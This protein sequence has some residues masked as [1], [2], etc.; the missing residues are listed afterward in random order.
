MTLHTSSSPRAATPRTVRH[1]TAFEQRSVLEET[2]ELTA[3][4]LDSFPGY[5]A[6]LDASGA[7]FAAN[8]PWI[9]LHRER[10]ED[11]IAASGVG[12]NYCSALRQIASRGREH[13]VS[14]MRELDDLLGGSG[15][16]ERVELICETPDGR[17]VAIVGQRLRRPAGGAA[18]TAV[19]I[20]AWATGA[21]ALQR[22]QRDLMDAAPFAVAGE[23]VGGIAHDL[24]QPL[25]SMQVNLDT[26]SYMLRQDP[27]EVARALD[28]LA[29]A[30]SD[31]RTLRDSVQLLQDLVARREPRLTTVSLDGVVNDVARL[32]HGEAQARRVHLDV[33][34]A[35]PLSPVHADRAMLREAVLGLALDAVEQ[36]DVDADTRVFLHAR[37]TEAS[38]ELS[39]GHQR[40]AGRSVDGWILA[41]AR[42]V[43]EAHSA[44]VRVDESARRITVT[45]NWPTA[46]ESA[47]P[48]A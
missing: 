14:L 41:V 15:P 21:R 2:A 47:G 10:G 8:T 36:A 17:Q 11:S 40:L 6:L 44:T 4:M 22:A 45:M 1:Q 39:I 24:R 33:A 25:T 9:Q 3:A 12:D 43:A 42:T 46:R 13:A 38:V 31:S 27:P 28:V 26:A 23:L 30:S 29:D 48:R 7:V 32:L 5:V 34:Y 35:V 37:N 19:D 20:T 18:L 16:N